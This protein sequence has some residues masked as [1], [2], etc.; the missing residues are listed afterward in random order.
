MGNFD[1]A[2]TFLERAVEGAP[3]LPELRYH[4]GMANYRSGR[5]SQARQDLEKA[6]G[7]NPDYPGIDQARAILA[8]LPADE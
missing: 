7:N 5:F 2:L 8:S 4:L 3:S 6:V 1:Q